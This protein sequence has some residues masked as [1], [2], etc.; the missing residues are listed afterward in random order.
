MLRER[1][2]DEISQCSNRSSI[3]HVE[4]ETVP[5]E[6]PL[7]KSPS[8]HDEPSPGANKFQPQQY[9]YYPN[10]NQTQYQSSSSR[11]GSMTRK[12]P[13]PMLNDL[14][15]ECDHM[16][17]RRSQEIEHE[18][19]SLSYSVNESP[20]GDANKFY[21]FNANSNDISS[22]KRLTSFEEI[23]KN[24]E[25]NSLLYIHETTAEINPRQYPS[26]GK[27]KSDY[28]IC[29]NYK[30]LDNREELDYASV[31]QQQM[32]M[33]KSTSHSYNIRR[34]ERKHSSSDNSPFDYD[35]LKEK[36]KE[37]RFTYDDDLKPLENNE[38]S[39]KS[40]D[41]FFNSDDELEDDEIRSNRASKK[42][43]SSGTHKYLHISGTE[44]DDDENSSNSPTNNKSILNTPINDT[45][46][47][48]S[49]D[50]DSA[51]YQSPAL[52]SALSSSRQKSKIPRPRGGNSNN[53]SMRKS[54]SVSSPDSEGYQTTINRYDNRVE[55]TVV[56]QSVE[57]G[58]STPRSDN[59][60]RIKINQKN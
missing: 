28:N 34:G 7:H 33:K 49:N 32:M 52:P 43:N 47:L 6:K 44:A 21:Q 48:L 59:K 4:Y 46:P 2:D 23:A 13:S 38:N 41:R 15:V 53:S 55:Q 37:N 18:D 24:S 22:L 5:L 42:S 11:R 14:I 17:V 50:V 8:K 58:G 51:F 25:N 9:Y 10:P 16:K 54:P 3:V 36:R 20:P 57:R 56:Y 39:I 45:M 29:Y 35:L 31:K 30:N 26:N 12:T 60:I 19:F 27:P 1:N 40:Y